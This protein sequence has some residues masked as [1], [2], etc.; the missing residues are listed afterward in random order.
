MRRDTLRKLANASIVTTHKGTR[1]VVSQIEVH[2]PSLPTKCKR[3]S[4]TYNPEVGLAPVL[5]ERPLRPLLGQVV[6]AA[7]V[8]DVPESDEQGRPDV[9]ARLRVHQC[10]EHGTRRHGGGQT[11][12]RTIT[13]HGAQSHSLS[14]SQSTA[15]IISIVLLLGSIL[16]FRHVLDRFYS[17]TALAKGKQRA[18]GYPEIASLTAATAAT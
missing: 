1:T 2:L 4:P 7:A 6:D 11:D 5:L 3:L 13:L 9:A 18:A 8:G 12:G 10:D 16:S 14:L 17:C 15:L